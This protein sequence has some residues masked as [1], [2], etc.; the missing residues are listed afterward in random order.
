MG[1]QKSWTRLGKKTTT[2]VI[3]VWKFSISLDCSFSGPLLE[4]LIFVGPFSTLIAISELLAS[5]F[6]IWDGMREKESPG[7]S[8]LYYFLRPSLWL[9]CL[10]PHF[11]FLF[12]FWWKTNQL[13]HFPVLLMRIHSISHS[14]SATGCHLSPFSL[15][16]YSKIFVGWSERIEQSQGK[17]KASEQKE[18]LPTY[19]DSSKDVFKT[20]EWVQT[21]I[22]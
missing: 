11:I 12:S 7:N 15:I 3:I 13:W 22:I 6:H 2:K 16:P 9:V 20:D 8:L 17:L 21:S 4:R 19:S 14:G 1:A 18:N 5:Q 10:C